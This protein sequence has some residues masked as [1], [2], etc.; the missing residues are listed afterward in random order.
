LQCSGIPEADD[1]AGF[2]VSGLWLVCADAQLADKQLAKVYGKAAV[3]APPMSVPHLDTRWIDG[4]RSLLFGPF[5]GFSSKFLKQGSL[6]DLPASVRPTNLLP[7][8]QVGATNMKLV[9]YLI[10]QLRQS[11][12]QRHEALQQFMPTARAEDW[13]LSVAGQRVQIIKRSKQGGRLQL[14]TEVVASKDGSLA[15]LLGASP[16]ASTAVTI[17]LEVLQRCFKDR[18]ASAPWQERL[19]AL[20]PSIG[21]DPVQDP[22]LLQ[23][24]RQRSDALLGL[25]G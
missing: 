17:M 1:F 9:Q 25:S 19:Q 5:A 21:G 3:G 14:G 18:L 11:P 12:E 7:M 15:A 16:G 6:F 2:P 20:L 23:A 4:K 22:E 10:N 8:L 13:S 24:M